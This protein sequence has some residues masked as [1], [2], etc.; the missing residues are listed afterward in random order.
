MGLF[1][2]S[3]RI[4]D[5]IY[6]GSNLRI[7]VQ[8]DR[9]ILLAN[10]SQGDTVL[11]EAAPGE[12][13]RYI[14][15]FASQRRLPRSGTLETDNI[16]RVVL[17]W[18]AKDQTWR[19]GLI[20]T[21]ALAEA[22][23]SRWCELAYWPG[24]NGSQ[25]NAT[26][27]GRSLAQRMGRPFTYIPPQPTDAPPVYPTP[28]PTAP[29]VPAVN[30]PP[31]DVSRLPA[32]PLRLDLWTLENADGVLRFRLAGSWGRARLLRVLWYVLWAAVFVVL[33]VVTLTSP[34]A[35]PRPEFLPYLGLAC[36][37]VLFLLALY[38]LL[39]TMMRVNL[40]EIEPGVVR[41]KRGY[42]ERWQYTTSEIQDVYASHLVNKVNARR[43]SPT[44]QFH[45]GELNLRLHDGRFVHLLAQGGL[46]EKFPVIPLGSAPALSDGDSAQAEDARINQPPV[47]PLTPDIAQTTLQ[48]AAIYAAHALRVP[49]WYDQRT[50]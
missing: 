47:V 10:T 22:R 9:W 34:I 25:E 48:A 20:F 42:R 24:E 43:S 28:T 36:A 30:V 49:A 26:Q 23:G 35:L 31:S 4:M 29:P 41:G 14:P 18:S 39:R 19:L 38:T 17:G 32:L 11:A 40:I 5:R 15:D 8:P 6:A 3:E 37:V 46:D 2:L 50:K 33:S 7:E 12:P 27:A 13:L 45:Y 1:S 44:R 21:P 16:E